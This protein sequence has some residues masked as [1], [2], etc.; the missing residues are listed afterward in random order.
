[1]TRKDY[2]IIAAA[3][4]RVRNHVDKSHPTPG[5]EVTLIHVVHELCVSLKE[6]NPRFDAERF[7]EA[8]HG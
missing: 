2:K 8:T 6:E 1:M 4:A 7:W 5:G 3:I